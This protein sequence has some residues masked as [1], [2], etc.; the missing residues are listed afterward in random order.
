MV[1]YK[2]FLDNY[3]VNKNINRC[4]CTIQFKTAGR[5]AAVFTSKRR[6][7]CFSFPAEAGDSVFTRGFAG[8]AS[9]QFDT[10]RV[11]LKLDTPLFD[12]NRLARLR[13]FG[14]REVRLRYSLSSFQNGTSGTN[15]LNSSCARTCRS[16]RKKC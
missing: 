3:K 14:R 1:K 15:L 11:T 16:L 4:I 13:K 6:R 2:N 8:V 7:E 12:K 9:S 10:S 5:S